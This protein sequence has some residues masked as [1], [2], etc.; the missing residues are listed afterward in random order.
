MTG[1]VVIASEANA[2]RGNLH[3]QQPH[4]IASAGEISLSMTEGSTAPMHPDKSGN[5]GF[6]LPFPEIFAF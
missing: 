4:E 1:S 6:G 3:P 2:E 5:H